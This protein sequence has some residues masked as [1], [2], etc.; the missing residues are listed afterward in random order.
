MDRTH[1]VKTNHSWENMRGDREYIKN[2]YLEEI[3]ETLAIICDHLA[4]IDKS[5]K[6][7]T[8]NNSSGVF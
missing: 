8:N 1:E 6:E 3:S 5:L 4:S 7:N 2:M